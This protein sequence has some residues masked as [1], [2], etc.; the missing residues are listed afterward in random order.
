MDG[1]TVVEER[2]GR[3]RMCVRR[4][5]TW[6]ERRDES[7]MEKK[8][9]GAGV[10]RRRTGGRHGRQRRE[11]EVSGMI[12]SIGAPIWRGNGSVIRARG[13]S[14]YV[15]VCVCV[16]VCA[17]ACRVDRDWD[18]EGRRKGKDRLESKDRKRRC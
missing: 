4:S 15:Y 5:D 12:Y 3:E 18:T 6:G 14:T 13:A 11:G 8:G 17:W 16:Y 9:E 7:G 10:A 2:E 1:R